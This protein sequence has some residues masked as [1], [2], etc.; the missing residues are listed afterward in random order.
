MLTRVGKTARQIL[1]PWRVLTEY[2]KPPLWFLVMGKCL[3]GFMRVGGDSLSMADWIGGVKVRDG[4]DADK[5][6]MKG[7]MNGLMSNV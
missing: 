7:W 3:F 6:G 1:Q 5:D 4:Q 2:A